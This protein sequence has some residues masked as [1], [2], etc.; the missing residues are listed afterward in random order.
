MPP[1][2]I[3]AAGLG[4]RNHSKIHKC[5]LP[6]NNKAI[7]SHIIDK[8]TEEVIIAVGHQKEL[9]KDYCHAAHPDRN[10]TFVEVDNYKDIGSGPGYSLMC[11]KE[12]LQRPFY[13]I[14]SDCLV[15]EDFPSLNTNWLGLYPIS[16]PENWST[17]KLDAQDNI[18]AFRNKSIYGH[19]HA[20]IGLAGIK[21]Y[22]IFWQLMKPF[23]DKEFEMVSAFYSPSVYPELKAKFFTWHDTGTQENYEKTKSML[24]TE[25]Y[26]GMKKN[27]PEITYKVKNRGIKISEQ[28]IEPKIITGKTLGNLIPPFVYEGQHAY[29]YDW[30]KGITL[31][32]KNSL[33]TFK[34]FLDW[35]EFNLWKKVEV[36]DFKLGCY[37]FY[38]DKTFE[39]L[40]MYLGKKLERCGF[41]IDYLN[42]ID[43]NK[44]SDGIPRQIHGDL[45]FENVIVNDTF[46][47]IDWRTTHH[48]DL[49]YDF[50]KIGA[51]LTLSFHKIKKSNFFIKDNE[52]KVPRN[53]ELDKMNY[54]FENW[55]LRKGYDLYKVRLLTALVYLNMAPL[56][57]SPVDDLLF[58]HA[59]HLLELLI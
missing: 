6:I 36:S 24:W 54:Y 57:V 20:F 28:S 10:I 44:L 19:S 59:K 38:H 41:I 50:A 55:L 11:C 21:D 52:Y 40:D 56:H 1:L 33:E 22:E 29:A 34:K 32:E 37:Q 48:F 42:K 17:A 18:V 13:L 12:Y 3:L 43:W 49:Y 14:C 58:Y 25:T 9:I 51:S 5:L 35:C 26:L 15:E 45:Q 23:D 8:T 39:R 31:Y 30:V 7:I 47:L 53:P 46:V 4:T 16:D 2:C 27:I